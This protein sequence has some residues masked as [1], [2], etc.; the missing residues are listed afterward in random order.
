MAH[1]GVGP[2]PELPQ[3]ARAVWGQGMEWGARGGRGRH[4]RQPGLYERRQTPVVLCGP[5]VVTRSTL[6]YQP[7]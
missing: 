6:A 2:W 5:A 4:D 3:P 7:S 1:V